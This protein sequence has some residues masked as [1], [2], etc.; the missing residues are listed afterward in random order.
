MYILSPLSLSL[1]PLIVIPL[2]YLLILVRDEPLHPL[3]NQRA[4]TTH[5]TPQPKRERGRIIYNSRQ[6][7]ITLSNSEA[8]EGDGRRI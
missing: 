5:C 6:S 8:G 7:S 1:L 3:L 4:V 2:V